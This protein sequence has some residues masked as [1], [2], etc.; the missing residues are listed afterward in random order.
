MTA[1]IIRPIAEQT[2]E[3]QNAIG[4]KCAEILQFL[5]L[6][7]PRNTGHYFALWESRNKRSACFAMDE[8]NDWRQRIVDQ[9]LTWAAE[10]RDVYFGTCPLAKPCGAAS[11]GKKAD[12]G[13][14]SA[15]WLDVDLGVGGHVAENL[16]RNWGDV[17]EVFGQ[18]GITPTVVVNS[19]GGYHT[20]F[21]LVEPVVVTDQNR[22]D[23]EEIL[24]RFQARIRQAFAQR[25]WKLD[26][27][28]DLTRVL[29]VPGTENHKLSA[30]RPVAL[31]PHRGPSY[32]FSALAAFAHGPTSA[33][34]AQSPG[35]APAP[36]PAADVVDELTAML[37][38][39][40]VPPPAPAPETEATSAAGS[41][42]NPVERMW[43]KLRKMRQPDRIGLVKLAS[44]GKPFAGSGDRDTCLQR[45]ASWI[46]RIDRQTEP[47]VLAEGILGRSIA[48]MQA[49]SAAN[50]E[51][52]GDCPSIEVAVEK[53]G[54][55]QRE[56]IEKDE[57]AARRDALIR[58]TLIA[59]ATPVDSPASVQRREIWTGPDEARVVGEV[60][61]AIA[62]H[63]M[64]RGGR[65]VT[66]AYDRGPL[67]GVTRPAGSP[68]VRPLSRAELRL[69]ISRVVF[70]ARGR[71]KEDPDRLIES[72]P[73]AWLVDGIFDMGSWPGVRHLEGIVESEVL[74]PDLQVISQPGY[75]D[76]TGLYVTINYK[77]G[78]RPTSR[79]E[80]VALLEEAVINFPFESPAH[81]A[82]WVAAL[83]TGFCL[84]AF[85]GPIPLVLFDANQRGSGK[86]RLI[87]L[88]AII[89]FGHVAERKSYAESDEETRKLITSIMLEGLSLI[90]L[91]NIGTRLGCPSLEAALTGTSWRDRRLGSNSTVSGPLRVMWLASGNNT[92]LSSDLTRRT[93]H[94]RLESQLEDPEKRCDL[95][96]PDLYAWAAE[97][98][99]RLIGA[100]LMIL[101]EYVR[102]G[103]PDMGL[104]AFGSFEGWSRLVRNATVWGGFADPCETREALRDRADSDRTFLGAMLEGL[105]VLDPES[106]GKTSRD[107]LL[108][109]SMPGQHPILA[110]ALAEESGSGGPAT[111]KSLGK[112]LRQLTG[113][114][115][116][117]FSIRSRVA[118]GGMQLWFVAPVAKGV[119]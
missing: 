9:A 38:P 56:L 118:H 68:A 65:L 70:L 80:A 57:L 13:L 108:A 105:R 113:R 74:G 77:T 67:A 2:T 58:S 98:R 111:A 104:P 69:L 61:E 97:N 47:Q 19:G 45:F 84:H 15:P 76:K 63:L 23:V 41:G 18:I 4:D 88:I 114:P 102:A 112:R 89:L 49:L 91:D 27:T 94:C 115:K 42:N 46:A 95:L 110:A 39:A 31:L 101:T 14:V 60:L 85:S 116:G 109:A 24:K 71:D 107:I 16:P 64:Q 22:S 79:K 87:D 32:S 11:R 75:H 55:A 100:C 86:T 66:L 29:R 17:A 93:L 51:K 10:G 106:K 50:G 83:L 33:P 20:Y 78:E 25:G 21:A 90:A 6:I 82:V 37:A 26:S 81:K 117:G 1:S 59:H 96:H 62:P 103:R 43:R 72:H 5:S 7:F 36:A 48:A 28:A 8:R 35:S 30:A 119:A 92:E 12:V 3:F 99:G 54:R 44:E 53:I 52:P 40:A 73:E 34:P